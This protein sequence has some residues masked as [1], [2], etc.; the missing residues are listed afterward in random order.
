MMRREAAA[1]IDLMP[2]LVAAAIWS[3]GPLRAR[4]V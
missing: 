3:V 1:A 4:P 2:A